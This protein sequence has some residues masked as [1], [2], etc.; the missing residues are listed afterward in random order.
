MVPANPGIFQFCAKKLKSLRKTLSAVIWHSSRENSQKYPPF[1]QKTSL[2]RFYYSKSEKKLSIK[3][4]TCEIL[5]LNNFNQKIWRHLCSIFVLRLKVPH[6]S[7][8]KG[9][10]VSSQSP[11]LGLKFEHTVLLLPLPQRSCFSSPERVIAVAPLKYY[12][13]SRTIKHFSTTSVV[14]RAA[15]PSS[16]SSSMHIRPADPWA[17]TCI[18]EN[19]SIHLV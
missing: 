19:L 16:S 11:N 9:F 8:H 13:I 1:P 17:R 15:Q 3:V 2:S 6:P 5:I 4:R 12:T 7:L 10:E 18:E 14:S